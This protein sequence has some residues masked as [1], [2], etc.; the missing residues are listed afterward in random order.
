M[1]QRAPL[2]TEERQK[3]QDAVNFARGNVQL[4]GG[5][6][7]DEIEALNARFIDG[8]LTSDEHTMHIMDLS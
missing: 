8:E 3:R 6:L 2:T 1:K 4:S 5:S 7:S